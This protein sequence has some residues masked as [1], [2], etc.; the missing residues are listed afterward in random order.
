MRAARILV[1]DGSH[2][3]Q[4]FAARVLDREG[5]HITAA[6]SGEGGLDAVAHRVPDL[7]MVERRLPDMCGL[8]LCRRLTTAAPSHRVPVI[9]LGEGLGD[10]DH[11]AAFD[12]D[13]AA[14]LAKPLN[15]AIALALIRMLLRRSQVQPPRDARPVRVRGLSIHVG[16]HEV[17]CGGRRIDLT[18]TELAVLRVLASRPGW[19]FTR[20]QIVDAIHGTDY[21]V[22]DRA[23]DAQISA[24]R[25]KLGPAGTLVETVR[26]V[27]YRLKR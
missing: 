2:D 23:I 12:A 19:V 5:Y 22:T 6:V 1:I 8:A 25:R 3:L 24:L 26:G 18:P 20:D 7:V 16:R 10:H 27:G 4:H 15:A 21:A 17:H 13:A 9:M 14:M 11:V